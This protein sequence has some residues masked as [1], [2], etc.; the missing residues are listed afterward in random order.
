MVSRVC[1]CTYIQVHAYVD[2][3][4]HHIS[5]VSQITFFLNYLYLSLTNVILRF[6]RVP[7]KNDEPLRRFRTR[8]NGFNREAAQN[9]A[10]SRVT[11]NLP[12]MN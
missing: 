6:A 9:M 3:T 1:T 12:E 2:S 8:A 4:R 7:T 5:L 10:E 11:M